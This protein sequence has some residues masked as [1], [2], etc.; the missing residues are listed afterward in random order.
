MNIYLRSNAIA[1]AKSIKKDEKKLLLRIPRKAYEAVK[2]S[3]D[4]NKRSV[5]SELEFSIEQKYLWGKL[6]GK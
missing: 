4:A 5:N 2:K 3:A 6:L 1:M